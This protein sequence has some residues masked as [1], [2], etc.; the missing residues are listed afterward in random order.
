ME[1]VL[2][3]STSRVNLVAIFQAHVEV[4]L[5]EKEFFFVNPVLHIFGACIILVLR[6]IGNTTFLLLVDCSNFEELFLTVQLHCN[7]VKE[8]VKETNHKPL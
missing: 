6:E 5:E 3:L 4:N 8:M 1:Q 7:L 2:S